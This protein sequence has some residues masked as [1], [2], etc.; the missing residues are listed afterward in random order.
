MSY[1]YCV[2]EC[3]GKEFIDQNESSR[4]TFKGLPGNVWQVPADN[5]HANL[6]IQKVL[7]TP[8]TRTEA[9]AIVDDVITQTQATWDADNVTNESAEQ[10]VDRIGLRPD[11]ITLEE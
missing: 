10:K 6:W 9:Q 1:K 7:G 5:N 4:I 2:A 11:L 3:W 8:K